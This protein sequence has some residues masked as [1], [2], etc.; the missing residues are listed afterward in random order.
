MFVNLH[1]IIPTLQK[2]RR[3]SLWWVSLLLSRAHNGIPEETRL[4][5]FALFLKFSCFKFHKNQA[6]TLPI[7][8]QNFL[9]QILCWKKNI[10]YK[11]IWGYHVFSI[12]KLYA[13]FVITIRL[14]I[15][16]KKISMCSVSFPMQK[17]NGLFKI[18]WFIRSL[19]VS[20]HIHVQFNCIYRKQVNS[21]P[22]K[23]SHNL[24]MTCPFWMELHGTLYRIK[25]NVS[26]WCLMSTVAIII[27]DLRIRLT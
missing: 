25:V 17:S 2:W 7:G 20:S 1:H 9:S 21:K 5:S 23:V 14:A 10:G 12:A 6:R 18:V 24:I 8:N 13:A 27:S 4:V 16:K 26:W 22:Y 19:S 3:K 11:F 15:L